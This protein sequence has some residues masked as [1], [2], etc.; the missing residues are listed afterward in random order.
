MSKN[1]VSILFLL[2]SN[3][4]LGNSKVDSLFS[5]ADTLIKKPKYSMISALLPGGTHF[6]DGKI[7]KGL[8]FFTSEISLL[9]IGVYLETKKSSNSYLNIPLTLSS[10]LYVIDKLEAFQ[11]AQLYYKITHPGY[12]FDESSLKEHLLSPFKIKNIVTPL[13]LCFVTF[14]IID[15]Y[16]TYPDNKGTISDI[17][18][19]TFYGYYLNKQWSNL[20]YTSSAIMISYGAGVTEEIIFRGAMLTR[21]DYLYGKKNGLLYTSLVFGAMHTPS[22]FKIKDPIRLSYSI[23]QVTS[24]GYILGKYVQNHN[25]QLSN[26]IAAHAWFDFAHM[27][28]VWIINP[29]E[30]PLGLKIN[31]NF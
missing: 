27:I 28:T 22:F 20:F 8:T 26:A 9:S 2:S 16:L 11:K 23:L 14:G 29:K 19:S 15:A 21:L 31:F 12:N 6:Q 1:V 17:S 3:V 7:A 25:Y 30:N 24:M 13:V 10:Q 4:I 5:S 18:S